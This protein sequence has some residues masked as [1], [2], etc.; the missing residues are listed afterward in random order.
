MSFSCAC[1]YS[2]D[3]VIAGLP[4]WI[5]YLPITATSPAAKNHQQAEINLRRKR[6]KVS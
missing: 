3:I 5:G 6:L 4:E 1:F 2:K